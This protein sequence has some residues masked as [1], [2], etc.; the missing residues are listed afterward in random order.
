MEML[1]QRYH[2]HLINFHK[3]LNLSDVEEIFGS[4][5]TFRNII[6]LLTLCIDQ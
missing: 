5:G 1:N 3:E 6:P 2:K 4:D